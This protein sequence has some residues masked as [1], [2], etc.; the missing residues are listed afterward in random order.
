MFDIKLSVLVL[1]AI[2]LAISFA[3]LFWAINDILYRI[4]ARKAGCS[5]PS[6]YFHWDPIL[7]LDLFIKRLSDMKAGDSIATDCNLLKKYGKIG[8][9]VQTN[10]FGVKQ[11]IISDPVNIQT[12]LAT[13]VDKFGNEPMNRKMC[14]DFLG[15]GVITVDG[16]CGKCRD[17]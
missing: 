16:H 10:A 6:K 7:G 15:D 14:A 13:Q 8:K 1:S 9:T 5:T 11:Y 2:A 4:A 12:I 17:S 3:L